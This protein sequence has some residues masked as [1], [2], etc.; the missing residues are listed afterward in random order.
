MAKDPATRYSSAARLR[1][2]LRRAASLSHVPAN[3]GARHRR[4]TLAAIALLVAV[5]AGSIAQSIRDSGVE[6]APYYSPG[7]STRDENRARASLARALADR[8]EMSRAEA[9][10]TARRWIAGAGLRA[11]VVAGFFDADLDYVDQ[12]RRSMTPRIESA[13]TAAA[14]ACAT[15]G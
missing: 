1:D 3:E 10:C 6:S 9:T 14:R 4:S 15:A 13:A 12:D 2:D 11:M 7:S 5:V 8:R